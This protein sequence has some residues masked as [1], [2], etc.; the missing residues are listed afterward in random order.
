MILEGI[1]AQFIQ[2]SYTYS[3][4]G[5]KCINKLL[6]DLLSTTLRGLFDAA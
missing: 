1:E 5:K 3:K 4:N 2:Q 6:K